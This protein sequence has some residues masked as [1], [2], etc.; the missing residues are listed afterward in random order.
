MR[1]HISFTIHFDNHHVTYSLHIRFGKDSTLKNI[2]ITPNATKLN[3]E[4]IVR[5]WERSHTPK[6]VL[7]GFNCAPNLSNCECYR[8]SVHSHL[9][10]CE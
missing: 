8:R 3:L 5:S 2:S 9:N 7:I 1:S 4:M 10:L 6:T